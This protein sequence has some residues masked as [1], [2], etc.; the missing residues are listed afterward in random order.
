[1]VFVDDACFVHF[2]EIEG[3]AVAVVVAEGEVDGFDGVEGDALRFVGQG[4]FLDGGLAAEV[5]E[6]DRAVG[7]GGAED[8]G[9]GGVVPDF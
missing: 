5:V 9:V 8:V 4:Y 7:A 1:V 3:V 2:A 6:D